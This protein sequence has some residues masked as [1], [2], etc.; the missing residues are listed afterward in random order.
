AVPPHAAAGS[1]AA[2]AAGSAGSGSAAVHPPKAN[3][4]ALSPLSPAQLAGQR[5]IYSYSGLTPPAPV[6]RWIRACQGARGIFFRG[7][8]SGPAQLAGVVA[9]LDRANASPRNPLRHYPLLLMTDQEGGLVR[10][11]PGAPELSEK[12]IGE[13]LRPAAAAKDAGRGAGRNLAGIGL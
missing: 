9:Q 10:R 12:Q 5:G 13:A 3:P 8:I 11:L 4:A 6:F 1:G 2:R 7:N